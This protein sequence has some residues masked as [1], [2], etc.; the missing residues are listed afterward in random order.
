MH[1]STKTLQ[2]LSKERKTQKSSLISGK[3]KQ[4]LRVRPPGIEWKTGRTPKMGKNWPKHRKWPSARNGEKMAQKWRNNRKT[5]PNPISAPF[6][7]H[8]SPFR[9]EGHFLFFGQFFP[10][11]GIR[12]V[13]HS[14]PGGLTRKPCLPFPLISEDFWVFLSLLSDCCVF[15]DKWAENIAIAEKIKRKPETSLISEKGLTRHLPNFYAVA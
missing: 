13:F 6:L 12:P 11:F 15:V 5:T 10:I 14:I 4:G 8:F 9:A 1:L 2:S 7:G 3:G